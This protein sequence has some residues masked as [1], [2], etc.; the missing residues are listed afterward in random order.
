MTRRTIQANDPAISGFYNNTPLAKSAG[1]QASGTQYTDQ[2][3]NDL[4]YLVEL[5]EKN[6]TQAAKDMKELGYTARDLA[7][8]KAGNVPMTEK[9]K[10]SSTEVMNAIKDLADPS[11]YE[12]NDAVGFL[13]GTPSWSGGDAANATMAIDNLVAKLTLPNL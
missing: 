6:P 12:W 1:T 9:Q 2:N 5:Q 10:N 8:Y 4:A 11:K 7:N 13:A 3:I